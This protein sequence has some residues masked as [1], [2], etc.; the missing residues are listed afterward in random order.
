MTTDEWG[1]D[2]KVTQRIIAARDH[3]R[4][5][6]AAGRHRQT[7]P[8][9]SDERFRE[10]VAQAARDAGLDL[11]VAKRILA[12]APT[13]GTCPNCGNAVVQH[14]GPGRP[15]LYCSDQCRF[16]HNRSRTKVES[17]IGRQVMTN[18]DNNGIV[19][20]DGVERHPASG[21]VASSPDGKF[22]QREL[23]AAMAAVN[24]HPQQAEFA[25]EAAA[26]AAYIKATGHLPEHL[27]TAAAAPPR[28]TGNP[29]NPLLAQ[30]IARNPEVYSEA[31]SS[32]NPPPTMWPGGDLPPLTASG[33]SP[34]FLTQLP[35]PA[36][37]SAA[38]TPSRAALYEL[39]T[40]YGPAS[41][42][43]AVAM[44]M[45][46]HAADDDLVAYVSRFETWVAA[47][48]SED[49][50]Y[51][52]LFPDTPEHIAASEPPDDNTIKP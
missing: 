17:S 47:N 42:P 12:G 5:A 11:D 45:L 43:D 8:K 16:E 1:L 32:G 44:A 52:R 39:A 34:Q 33:E 20:L 18:M 23:E 25:A 7:G 29:S 51:Q 49:Q 41:D 15:S 3:N 46:D 10:L 13:S 6:A 37:Y 14:G 38:R 2:P 26:T 31:M 48:Q 19:T 35:W 40:R 27:P 24:P 22:T 50:T 30:L 36:R 9:V 21:L 4:A 28:S